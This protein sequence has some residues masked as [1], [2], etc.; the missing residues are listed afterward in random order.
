MEHWAAE[1][2]EALRS[3]AKDSGNGLMFAKINTSWP[4]TLRIHDQIISKHLFRNPS[5]SL[6]EED[7]VLV[8][9]SGC[10]FYILLRVV[11]V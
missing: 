10:A 4:L 2:V 8:L 7:E 3:Q 11:P 1:M 6:L 5:L 9:K